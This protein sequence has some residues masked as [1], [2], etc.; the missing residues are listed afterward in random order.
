MSVVVIYDGAFYLFAVKVR[1][2]NYV[3]KLFQIKL[4]FG[5]ALVLDLCVDFNIFALLTLLLTE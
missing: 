1:V 5:K 3:E 2:K 4:G